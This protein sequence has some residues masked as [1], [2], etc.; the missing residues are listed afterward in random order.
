MIPD[1]SKIQALW[2]T[3]ALP[4]PKRIH[5]TWV[6]KVALFLAKELSV[7]GEQFTV[8]QKL[9]SAAAL[10]HD[11][12]KAVPRLPGEK[13]PDTGVRLLRREGMEEVANIVKTHSLHSVLDPAICPRSWEEKILYLSDKMVKYE[14][15]TVD[16]RFALWRAEDLPPDAQKILDTCYPKVKILEKEILDLIGLSPEDVAK[17]VK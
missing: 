10:L 3:Y 17:Q 11:I 15:I 16:K 7:H 2:D 6:S 5:V 9:L 12:D 1:N 8:N 4:P 13:H 14:V